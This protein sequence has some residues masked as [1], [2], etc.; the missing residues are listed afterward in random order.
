MVRIRQNAVMS[1]G[2]HFLELSLKGQW[3]LIYSRTISPPFLSHNTPMIALFR[4]S[5][6]F[7]N[8]YHLESGLL[9]AI[10]STKTFIHNAETSAAAIKF[11]SPIH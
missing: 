6:S 2:L 1:S 3:Q 5:T 10:I 11:T 9:M 7:S 8:A 4:R